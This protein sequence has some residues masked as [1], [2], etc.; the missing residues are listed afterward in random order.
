MNNKALVVN[1]FGCPGA[2]KSVAAAWLFAELKQQ[3]IKAE[4]VTEY[5][6]DK[7]WEESHKVL[8]NQI[9]VFSKQHHRLK[10]LLDKVDI[11]I[12]DSPIIMGL[13]YD[14]EDNKYLKDLA[15]YEYSKMQNLNFVL[16]RTTKFQQEGRRHDENQAIFYDQKIRDLIYDNNIPFHELEPNK[17]S[18]QKMLN[19]VL[20]TFK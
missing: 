3:G 7:V 14:I 17:E 13:V 8:H 6:K 18:Y 19:L 4:L 2:G 9:Y 16:N 15:F 20:K 1:V 11:I 12:N 5:A 10:I